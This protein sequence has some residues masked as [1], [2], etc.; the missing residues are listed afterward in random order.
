[1]PP[2]A[3]ANVIIQPTPYRGSLF[4]EFYYNRFDCNEIIRSCLE[5][6]KL[7]SK[8]NRTPSSLNSITPAEDS[9]KI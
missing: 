4:F 1:M 3:I 8:S 2:T 7:I 5:F 6:V 9:K